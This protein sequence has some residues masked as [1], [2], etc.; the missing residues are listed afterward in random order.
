MGIGLGGEKTLRDDGVVQVTAKSLAKDLALQY[1]VSKSTIE[2]IVYNECRDNL[3]LDRRIEKGDRGQEMMAALWREEE[4][5]VNRR[6]GK[7]QS[8]IHQV[9]AN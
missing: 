1:Q 8:G 2:R 7:A 3:S 5:R 9:S 4:A 6:K